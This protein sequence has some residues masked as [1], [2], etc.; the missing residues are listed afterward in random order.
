MK[1]LLVLSEKYKNGRT[2]DAT[3]ARET[4]AALAKFDVQ[5]KALYFTIYGEIQFSDC[6]GNSLSSQDVEELVRWC[7][8]V[9][10]LPVNVKIAAYFRRF[11]NRP[12]LGSPI[13]WGGLERVKVAWETAQGMLDK[14]RRCARMVRNN[15][16][17]LMNF[18]G[19]D[20]FL[21]NSQ[22]EGRCVL[23]HLQHNQSAIA[24]PV[25]NGFI[26]PSLDLDTIERDSE[27]PK[28]D[29][30]VVPG[31]FAC[32]KNQLSM[33]R[34]VKDMPYAFVFIGGVLDSSSDKRYYEKCRQAANSNMFFLGHIPSTSA[35]YWSVLA[36][37]RVSCLPSDCETP[38]IAM[39]ESAY[40][41]ARPCITKYGG[42][43]EY[44][45]FDGEYLDPCDKFSIRCAIERAWHRGRL[46][47]SQAN[48]YQRFSWEYCV[49]NT[50][51]AYAY[52]IM[53][54]K[55]GETIIR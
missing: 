24:F 23:S 46:T 1:V 26:V 47:K 6:R 20:V 43:E 30:V 41:G 9:H 33:I 8:I 49:E 29:Y 55:G 34:A 21:P 25:P 50:L 15:T 52:A 17:I 44:Y 54:Y 12:K 11:K 36:H 32:R 16:K 5:V 10:L 51:Q 19:I 28:E 48:A 45:G 40:A 3:Q 22:A 42:T 38:G 18:T 4:F 14:F 2:G 53:R 31:V 13:Y 35:R 7:D 37:A 39:I 27:V